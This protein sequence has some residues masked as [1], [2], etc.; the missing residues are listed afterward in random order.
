[1]VPAA[2]QRDKPPSLKQRLLQGVLKM[3]NKDL[4]PWEKIWEVPTISL[5]L[6]IHDY[7]IHTCFFKAG[8]EISPEDIIFFSY[9]SF[10][11]TPI[12]LSDVEG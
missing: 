5:S 11:L 2:G 3:L 12:P 10:S 4:W 7:W 9:L 1:M 8:W 6:W